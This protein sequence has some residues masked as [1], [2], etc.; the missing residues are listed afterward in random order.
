[1]RR[2]LLVVAVALATACQ[3]GEDEPF[4]LRVEPEFVQGVIPGER[5][6][7]L[8]T[9]ED[10]A[11]GTSEVEVTALGT[12]GQVGVDPPSIAAGEVAEVTYVADAVSEGQ[13][14]PMTLT[15][16]GKRGPISHE[17]EVTTVIVPWEDSL[18]DTASEILDV[19]RPWLAEN[20]PELG[21]DVDTDFEGTLVAPNL[22]VVSHYAF[23]NEEWEVGLGWHIMTAPDDWAEIYLRPR[24]EMSPTIAFRLNSWSSALAGGDFE[25]TEVPAPEQVQ[26]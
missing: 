11:A 22:L 7:M 16:T 6:V 3:A 21:I 5:L 15:I 1:M 12:G 8:V 13:E 25:I 17:Q 20:Q 4:T 14:V 2:L 10:T 26:R 24:D 9:V 19:F 18:A 23:F